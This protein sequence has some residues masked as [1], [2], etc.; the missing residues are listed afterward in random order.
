M[1]SSSDSERLPSEARILRWW[2]VVC[3]L[4]GLGLCFSQILEIPARSALRGYDNTFNYLWLRS[5]MVDGDW[6]F[7]NDLE[8]CDTLP[9][10]YRASAL[11]LPVSATGRI[12][13]KYGIGWSVVTL[14]FYLVAD[15]L[16]S[17][18]GSLNLTSYEN[19][20]FTPV[21][22]ICIQLG[23]VALAFLA[24]WIAVETIST[25]I[26]NK[27]AAAAGVVTV[28]AA[29]PLI[30]YQTV[31]VSMS[32][33]AA[34]FAVT[35]MAYSLT[36]GRTADTGW[37]WWA[38]AGVAFGLA[39]TVRYQLVVFIMPALWQIW[40]SK[41]EATPRLRAVGAFLM[42]AVPLAALQL[43]AWR[44]VYGD[45]FVFSYGVEGESFDWI[46]PEVFNSLLSSWHGLFYW[47]PFLL[48]GVGG[49]LSWAW[50]SSIEAKVWAL[51]F[52]LVVYVNS[53]WWCWWFASS[54]GNRGYDAALL[55]VMAGAGWLLQRARGGGRM[56]F[57]T[58]AM[59]LGLWNFYVVLL[60]RTGAISRNEPVAWWD[61][62]EAAGRL[63]E[64]TKF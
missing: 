40:R 36:R 53:A 28:W 19:D 21:Y 47:H 11:S 23:H 34:F 32:H 50:R 8:A 54:F 56:L 39:I 45:W 52:C 57:W 24:L 43:F 49:M 9:P 1:V 62:I 20:G 22:Q 3:V 41:L 6:D 26:G 27:E 42:G 29:S 60:Y 13:N 59:T 63:G 61:M 48:V 12:P 14:P 5:A 31:N 64:A 30:Y 37:K 2:I 18:A 44:R 4:V 10:A 55:P 58:A 38:V 33:G 51:V 15:L 7:R 16:T 25:W 17:A 35:L 46:K